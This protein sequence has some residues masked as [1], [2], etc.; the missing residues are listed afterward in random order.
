ML[1]N[2]DE[3]GRAVTYM[4]IGGKIEDIEVPQDEKFEDM[5]VYLQSAP[6]KIRQ[7]LFEELTG[8]NKY[9]KKEINRN[10]SPQLNAIYD[11]NP[12]PDVNEEENE[13]ANEIDIDEMI[14][15]LGWGKENK[16]NL[17]QNFRFSEEKDMEGL[18]ESIIKT[19][20]K[21]KDIINRK[22]D[23]NNNRP[24]ITNIKEINQKEQRAK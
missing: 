3:N 15:T 18:P 17:M 23:E 24:D 13:T 11:S 6:S 12:V 7:V 2:V 10:I 5:E 1:K 4:P 20:Q 9:K 21:V 14:K 19:R 16:G 8:L 22:Q